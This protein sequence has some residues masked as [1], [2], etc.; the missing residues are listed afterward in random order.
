LEWD[1]VGAT[2][3]T[4]SIQMTLP[5]AG[6]NIVRLSVLDT[7]CNVAQEFIDTIVFRPP[8]FLD[9]NTALT[10]CETRDAVDF[11]PVINLAYQGFEWLVDGQSVGSPSP[12][13]ITETGIYEISLIAIDSLCGFAD[14]LTE[15]F[16]I[17]FAGEAFEVPNVITPNGDGIN[18]K[19][20]VNT[21][22]NWDEFHVILYNR[23]G[24]KVFETTA[25]SFEWGADFDGK[26]LTPGVYFYQLEATNRCGDVR[27]DGTLHIT[28]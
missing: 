3:T 28:Y 6:A 9:I 16:D 17:Y 15:S 7:A 11:N 26:I 1:I 8:P 10:E 2:F 23:W 25:I 19:W 14:T 13:Q 27:D 4:N 22:E 24:I 20:L 21:S 18:D 5:S 12:L